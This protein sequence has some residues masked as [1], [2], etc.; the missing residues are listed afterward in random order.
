MKMLE[1]KFH[2]RGGQGV[3]IA[4]Q[5]LGMA[6]FGMDMYPQCYSLF[7]GERRGAPVVSFLRVGKEKIL[8]KCEIKKPN[9]LIVFDASL[10]DPHEIRS[11]MPPG[12]RILVNCLVQPDSFSELAGY[13]LGCVDAQSIAEGLDL[14]H[15]INT[16]ILGAYCRF[17]GNVP[18]ED[19][20]KTVQK[21]A[22]HRK[23]ANVESARL[24]YENLTV[25]NEGTT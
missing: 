25:V 18:L 17:T 5:I 7:G 12:S 3:V 1:I 23:D 21:M 22:P 2:G 11:A 19:L 8:L 9:E 15:V 10:L 16:A 6:F 4:S 20:L 13:E 24:G 14:G